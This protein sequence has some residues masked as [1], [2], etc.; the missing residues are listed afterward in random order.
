ME[1]KAQMKEEALQRS[2][3]MLEEDAMR[4]DAFLKENDKKAHDAI[5]RAEE[6]SKRKQEKR[7]REMLEAQKV[8]HHAASDLGT[9]GITRALQSQ[10]QSRGQAFVVL[11]KDSHAQP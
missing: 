6:E 10:R 9:T 2:E 7:L 8:Q 3:Q 4:F 11:S 1:E 5:K